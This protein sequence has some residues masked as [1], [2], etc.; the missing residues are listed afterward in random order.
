MIACTAARNDVFPVLFFPDKQ[1]QRPHWHLVASGETS[2]VF[3][4]ESVQ[5]MVSY[6]GV[7]DATRPKG[8]KTI[9]AFDLANDKS[10]VQG[11]RKHDGERQ[12]NP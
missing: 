7:I 4:N 9:F 1:G 5:R 8:N 6:F 3:Q 10:K 11:Y 2:E 12:M